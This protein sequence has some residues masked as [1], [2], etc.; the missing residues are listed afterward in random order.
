MVFSLRKKKVEP[1]RVQ[2]LDRVTP[3]Y[4]ALTQGLIEMEE[5]GV[6]R[7]VL[8]LY[9]SKPDDSV[10]GRWISPEETNY[11][12]SEMLDASE[13][14]MIRNHKHY[15]IVSLVRANVGEIRTY[16]DKGL[17]VFHRTAINPLLPPLKLE[18][19]LRYVTKGTGCM[20]E[21]DIKTY[22]EQSGAVDV[23]APESIEQT[24]NAGIQDYKATTK[25]LMESTGVY[26]SL[27]EMEQRQH[28]PL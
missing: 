9:E 18:S 25:R 11:Y 14:E 24:V 6:D 22:L 20:I 7:L 5:K 12:P 8:T 4:D 10:R 13:Q 1:E 21:D 2:A 17:E 28:N 27:K 15:T 3:I 16:P 26:D 23:W 19:N